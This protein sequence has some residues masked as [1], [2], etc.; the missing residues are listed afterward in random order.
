M[1]YW[2]SP[3]VQVKAKYG[4]NITLIL[5]IVDSDD[6]KYFIPV[7]FRHSIFL[8]ISCLSLCKLPLQQKKKSLILSIIPMVELDNLLFDIVKYEK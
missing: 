7:V 3:V 2:N 1:I 5:E 4:S 6:K 8:Y